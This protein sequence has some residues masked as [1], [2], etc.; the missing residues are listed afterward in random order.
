VYIEVWGGYINRLLEIINLFCKTAQQKRLF[1][2]KE[3]YDFKEP[4]NR[5]HPISISIASKRVGGFG[6][7]WEGEK[8]EQEIEKEK[9]KEHAKNRGR[10]RR[11]TRGRG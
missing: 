11:R 9:E 3:T 4:T 5:S 10:K 2:A 8:R 6:R 7:R 1:F